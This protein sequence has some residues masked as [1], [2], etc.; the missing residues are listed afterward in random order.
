VCAYKIGTELVRP[1]AG[2][3]WWEFIERAGSCAAPVAL[4]VVDRWLVDR[5]VRP[6]PDVLQPARGGRDRLGEP[7]RRADSLTSV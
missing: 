3:P 1:M 4:I 7:D 6:E 5:A 2:E